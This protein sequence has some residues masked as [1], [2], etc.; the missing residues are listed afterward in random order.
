MVDSGPEVSACFHCSLGAQ[1][2]PKASHCAFRGMP[3]KGRLSSGR[4]LALTCIPNPQLWLLP[5]N[6]GWKGL[7]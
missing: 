1:K 6:L 3:A 5:E 7:I 4:F 2:S